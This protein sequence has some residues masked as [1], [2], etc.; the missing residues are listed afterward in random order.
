M[1]EFVCGICVYVIIG[2]IVLIF[3]FVGIFIL[4]FLDW[5]ESCFV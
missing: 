5:D 1:V 2:L 4:L 3:V